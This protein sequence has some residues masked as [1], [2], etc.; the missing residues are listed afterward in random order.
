MSRYTCSSPQM[1]GIKPTRSWFRICRDG[2]PMILILY[3][4][5]GRLAYCRLIL[6]ILC[7]LTATAA[8]SQRVIYPGSEW[9]MAA[10]GLLPQVQRRV[11]EYVHA[12]DTTGLM[13][14]QHGRVVYQY[15]D[16]QVLSYSASTRKSILAML[17]GSYVANGTI[18]L[19]RTLKDLGMS[20]LGGLL[21]NEERAKVVDL[22]SARSGVYHPASNAGDL[23]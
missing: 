21:P 5:L 22:I 12:L 6:V 14:V 13:V 10:H 8:S 19:D 9:E 2:E 18:R 7:G 23:L 1:R 3:S 16:L 17:Y 15:G 11:D 20:D 4:L